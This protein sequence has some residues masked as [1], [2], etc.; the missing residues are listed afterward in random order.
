MK[1]GYKADL[2]A[3]VDEPKTQDIWQEHHIPCTTPLRRGQSRA[4]TIAQCAKRT[5]NNK[6]SKR[7]NT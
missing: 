4:I 7:A 3:H 5:C 6:P 2:Y 1:P